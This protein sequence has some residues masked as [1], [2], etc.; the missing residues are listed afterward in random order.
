MGL[1]TSDCCT[2]DT[3]FASGDDMVDEMAAFVDDEDA[4][5]VAELDVAEASPASAGSVGGDS[6]GGGEWIVGEGQRFLSPQPP[7]SLSSGG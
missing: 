1:V 3:T 4:E 6:A 5:S 2:G 7:I